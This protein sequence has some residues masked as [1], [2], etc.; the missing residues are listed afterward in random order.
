M[1]ELAGVWISL[2]VALGLLMML[3]IAL[4]VSLEQCS[5][6]EREQLELA[7]RNADLC[8][9]QDLQASDIDQ[10]RSALRAEKAHVAQLLR[11]VELLKLLLGELD[12]DLQSS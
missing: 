1:S 2:G 8:R 10:L 4:L 5:T 3:G 11:K 12:A 7:E 9:V 6:L